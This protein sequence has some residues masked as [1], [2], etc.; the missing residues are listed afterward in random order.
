[1]GKEHTISEWRWG[2]DNPSFYIEGES[3]QTAINYTKRK[4]RRDWIFYERINEKNKKFAKEKGIRHDTLSDP[5]K[6]L[7]KIKTFKSSSPARSF[8]G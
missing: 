4:H 2:R 8:N 5:K 3:R 1:M 6:M 7:K